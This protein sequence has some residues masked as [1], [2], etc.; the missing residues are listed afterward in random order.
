M[1]SFSIVGAVGFVLHRP[2]VGHA[3][4]SFSLSGCS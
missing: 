4:I 1:G 2:V 3:L